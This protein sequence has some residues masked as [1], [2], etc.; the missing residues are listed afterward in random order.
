MNGN[1]KMLTVFTE[2]AVN[3]VISKPID[4]TTGRHADL[5]PVTAGQ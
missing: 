3:Q 2:S 4:R 1:S 5:V